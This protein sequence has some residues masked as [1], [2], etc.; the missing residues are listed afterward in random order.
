MRLKCLLLTIVAFAIS[1]GCMHPTV[2]PK[3]AD[4][5]TPNITIFAEDGSWKLS[6]RKPFTPPVVDRLSGHNALTAS[7]V[8]TDLTAYQNS[9][10][11]KYVMDVVVVVNGSEKLNGK[12][13]FT[14]V[15]ENSSSPSAKRKWTIAIPETYLDIARQGNV[16]VVYQPYRY[17]GRDWASW[18]LWISSLPL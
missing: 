14:N 12:L 16:A 9:R 3:F 7:S 10:F 4:L 11:E 2:V 8:N 5:T 15:Y 13:L 1:T 17:N 6:Y 18:V